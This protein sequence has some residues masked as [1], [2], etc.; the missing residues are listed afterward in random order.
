MNCIL[1]EFLEN[2]NDCGFCKKKALFYGEWQSGRYYRTDDGD[3]FSVK[4]DFVGNRQV[5]Y[6]GNVS[7]Q[8]KHE[9]VYWKNEMVDKMIEF[10]D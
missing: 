6:H 3:T 9:M 10:V 7:D 5:F 8:E 2:C 1:K 4:T